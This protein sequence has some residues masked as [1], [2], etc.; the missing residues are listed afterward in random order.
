M[1]PVMTHNLLQSITLCANASRILS[2]K[3]VSGITANREKCLSNA[4]S[5]LAMATCLVPE[6]GYD[7]ASDIAGKAFSSNRTVKEVVLEEAVMREEAFDKLARQFFGTG[8]E[9]AGK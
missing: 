1:I 5:S 3:C 2:E 8:P 9:P 4:S 6:I 7:R